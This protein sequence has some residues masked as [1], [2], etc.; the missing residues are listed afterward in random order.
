MN[1]K[2]KRAL[3]STAEKPRMTAMKV[4]CEAG[5][6]VSLRTVQRTLYQSEFMEFEHLKPSDSLKK[7]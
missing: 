4:L 6:D 5:F 2:V 1:S 3:V 7:T